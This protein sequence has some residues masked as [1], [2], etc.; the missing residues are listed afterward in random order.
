MLIAALCDY[1]D[2]LEKR[3]E[4][5]PEG[6]SAVKVHYLVALTP[7]GKIDNIIDRQIRTVIKPPEDDKSSKRK[8][9]EIVAPRIMNMMKRSEVTAICSNIIEHRPLYL[10]GLN[11]DGEAF[12]AEDRT[13]KAKKSHAAFVQTNQDF[14]EGIDTPVVNAFRIFI[15]E[16]KPEEETENLYLLKLG[17]SYGTS[18]YAFCLS[19]RPD[20]MLHEDSQVKAKWEAMLKEPSAN[21]DGV[22]AQCGIL[23]IQAPIAR[24]HDKIRGVPTGSSMGNTLISYKNSAES[25]Y[26]HE[27]SYNSNV[28]E[29]AMKKYTEALNIL[30]ADKRHQAL[31]ADMPIVHW[32]DSIDDRYDTMAARYAFGDTSGVEVDEMDEYLFGLM[33]RAREGVVPQNI[34]ALPNDIDPNVCFYMVG[35]KPNS[36]RLAVKF[37]YRRKFGVLMQNIARHQADIQM[38]EN[39][40]PVMLWQ[41]CKELVSPK[42]TDKKVDPAAIA[43]LLEAIVYGYNYPEFLLSTLVRRVKTD[44]DEENNSYIKMNDV[45]MGL[46]KGCINRKTRLNGQ[47]EELGMALDKEYTNPAYLCGR[48][49]AVLES[50]QLRASDYNLN[51]TIKDTY[52]ASAS[53][54]PAQVFPKLMRLSSYHL[55][56]LSN[57]KYYDDESIRE[58]VK[59]MGNEFPEML[60]LIEQGKFMLGYYNQKNDIYESIKKANEAKAAKAENNK[61]EVE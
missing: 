14:L 15:S 61:K 23:G 17:K 22:T 3:G 33:K 46:I 56:K 18:G 29:L 16:W 8:P 1:Y 30:L 2:M 27:Q 26:G 13:D 47:K 38:R 21:S 53:T 7:D 37:V 51:R 60:P 50:I 6:Y 25:S 34:D 55:S 57:S 44:S 35:L 20:E 58:I 31:L 54:R 19:G 4:V 59:L 48:L 10:F 12:S 40:R 45:R 28:S 36:A 32:A 43:K 24:I 11:F 9:K 52:F 42:S 5:L 41:I 49:F 39:A